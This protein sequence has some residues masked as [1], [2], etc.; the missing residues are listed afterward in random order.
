MKQDEAGA[1]V[2]HPSMTRLVFLLVALTSFALAES[3]PNILFIF[4]DDHALKGIGAYGGEGNVAKTPNLDR[5][6]KEGMLF[7][8]CL[9]TNSICGPTRKKASGLSCID[10]S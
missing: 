5:L 10:M 7:R 4:S 8:H 9:V 1:A 3:K 2:S 6:A